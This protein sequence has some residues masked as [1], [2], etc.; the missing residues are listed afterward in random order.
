MIIDLQLLAVALGYAKKVKLN[1]Q[2]F[3]QKSPTLRS[4]LNPTGATI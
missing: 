2:D 1:S 3:V 4:V